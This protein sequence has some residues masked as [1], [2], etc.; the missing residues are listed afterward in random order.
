[1]DINMPV[2]NGFEAVKKIKEKSQTYVVALSASNLDTS[3]LRSC[4]NAGFDDQFC[5]PLS[6]TDLKQKILEKVLTQRIDE[7]A[8]ECATPKIIKRLRPS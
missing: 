2:M 6:S 4:Q 8:E 5:I 3:L 7:D 1:M